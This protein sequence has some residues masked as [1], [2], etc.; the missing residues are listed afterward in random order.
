[1]QSQ[2]IRV[3]TTNRD[4]V[5]IIY[6]DVKQE[7]SVERGSNPAIEEKIIKTL[8]SASTIG[9]TKKQ[10]AVTVGEKE[11]TIAKH[12]DMLSHNGQVNCIGRGLWILREYED[13]AKVAEFT[14]PEHYTRL[15][16]HDYPNISFAQFNHGITF[17]H[18]EDKS[19]HR[20]SPYVQGFSST[21][22]DAVLAKYKLPKGSKVA[23]CYAGSGTV[24]VCAKMR[25]LDSVGVELSP[26][27]TFMAKVKT[28][29]EPDQINVTTIKQEAERI[30]KLWKKLNGNVPVPFLRETTAHFSDGILNSLSVLKESILTVEDSNVQ[31][32]FLLAFASILI[33]SSNLKRS[34]CL[35]YA[36]KKMLT[37]DAPF[38]YFQEKVMQMIRD[39]QT[40]QA[41]RSEWADVKIVTGDSRTYSYE[42]NSLKLVVTSPPYANGLDYVTN[43]K[44]EMA[45]LGKASSY[46]DLRKLRDQMV[47]CDNISRTAI[48]EF[49]KEESRFEDEWLSKII[50]DVR[51]RVQKKGTFRRNDMHLVVK[52][53]FEDLYQ[54]F[55][56]VY[57]GLDDNG[58]FVV[59]IGD[60][61][62]A[63]TY[64]PTDLILARVGKAVG[65]NV[66][67]IQIARIRRSGQRRSFKL[68]E[69]IVTLTK[70]KVRKTINLDNF[71]H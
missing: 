24:L 46:E 13:I 48:R 68:R 51:L 60:S 15:F 47:A 33:A 4:N 32:L 45:W 19:V 30:S 69:T 66:E 14:T 53:Y 71:V 49:A 54:T 44:L 20:W 61:L 23:D 8:K 3:G 63:G 12:L 50:E 27:L 29:W 39:I 52:K 10:L 35:G 42:P 34:P 18:N 43:Y 41:Q 6:A 62:M 26:L 59:V 58:R 65:F 57:E 56:K 70:G 22:V 25:Q 37:P 11:E 21:F 2:T 64:L 5:E 16:K 1:M 7:E 67:D 55:D 40:L 36:K 17:T 31:S 9:V 38:S 28:R